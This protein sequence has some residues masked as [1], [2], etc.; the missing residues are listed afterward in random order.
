MKILIGQPLHEDKIEQLENEIKSN[1]DIDFVFFPEGY[2]ANEKALVS[3]REIAKKYK[4]AIAT[5]YKR[6]NK[7][8]ALI[9]NNLGEIVLERAKTLPDENIK[10]YGPTSINIDGCEI[11]YLLCMEILKGRRDLEIVKEHMDFIVHPIGVGMFSDEQFELWISEAQNIAKAY[12]TMVIGTSHADGSY[13]NCGVSLPIAYCIDSNGEAIYI[14][15]SDTRTRIVNL[16][17]KEFEIK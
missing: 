14:S 3:A 5:S 11:G 1:K 10:L 15:K 12:N 4:V 13:R 2:L 6:D 7:N 9:I 17:S 16:T 8:R